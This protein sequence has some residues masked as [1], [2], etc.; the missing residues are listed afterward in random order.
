MATLDSLFSQHCGD[1]TSKEDQNDKLIKPQ[2]VQLSLSSNS[3]LSDNSTFCELDPAAAEQHNLTNKNGA[4]LFEQLMD[5]LFPFPEHGQN[6][7]HSYFNVATVNGEP[8]IPNSYLCPTAMCTAQFKHFASLQRHWATHPWNRRGILLPV[9][10]GGIPN[11]SAALTSDYGDIR[12]FGPKSF[13]VSP[14]VLCMEQVRFW[15]EARDAR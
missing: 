8:T 15:E 9:A 4:D 1:V 12:L 2:S 6:P 3:T 7:Y 13:F 10:A 11:N 5:T 14:R